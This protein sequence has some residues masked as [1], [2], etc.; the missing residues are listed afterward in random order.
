[1]G[2]PRIHKASKYHIRGVR[3]PSK[4]YADVGS[5]PLTMMF[6]NRGDLAVDAKYFVTQTDIIYTYLKPLKLLSS[7][8]AKHLSSQLARL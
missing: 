1:M 6:K 8:W 2:P 5:Q 4:G 3:G 7:N